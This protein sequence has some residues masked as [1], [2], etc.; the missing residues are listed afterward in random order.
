MPFT[1]ETNA[2][3][4]TLVLKSSHQIWY[5]NFHMNT[6]VKKMADSMACDFDLIQKRKN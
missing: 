2:V 6:C 3:L 5:A 4:E 1:M